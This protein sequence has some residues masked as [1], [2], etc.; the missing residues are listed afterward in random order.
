MKKFP[1]F[2]L[3]F[4]V[5][6]AVI[7]TVGSLINSIFAADVNAVGFLVAAVTAS[8]VVAFVSMM[9]LVDAHGK[10]RLS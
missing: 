8:V 9:L 4:A 1:K 2:L 6:F 3:L 7:F 5:E 10:W